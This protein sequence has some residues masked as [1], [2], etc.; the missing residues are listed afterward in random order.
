MPIARLARDKG[1]PEMRRKF[2]GLYNTTD[3]ADI[4]VRSR[5]YSDYQYNSKK[6]PQSGHLGTIVPPMPSRTQQDEIQT[7]DPRN[8]RGPIFVPIKY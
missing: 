5:A 1:R 4:G 8:L 6:N 3:V 2:T 7:K